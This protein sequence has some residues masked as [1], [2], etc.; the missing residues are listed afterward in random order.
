MPDAPTPSRP[1]APQ[2]EHRGTGPPPQHR[3]VGHGTLEA[4]EPPDAP[5]QHVA[6]PKEILRPGASRMIWLSVRLPTFRATCNWRSDL[7][8]P[9]TTFF[10]GRW[11]AKIKWS[12]AALP[13]PSGRAT[14][15]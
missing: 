10:S 12:P 15:Y 13:F 11:V 8:S 3:D 6:M 9:V 5:H 4:F 14:S 1:A 7:M 2:V